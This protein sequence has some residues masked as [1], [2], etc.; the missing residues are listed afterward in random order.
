MLDD[1]EIARYSEL[2]LAAMV[3]CAQSLLI[4]TI[5]IISLIQPQFPG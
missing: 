1:H 2:W 5:M 3:G 4:V